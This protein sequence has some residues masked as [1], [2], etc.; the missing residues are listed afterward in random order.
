MANRPSPR[1][2]GHIVVPE[3]RQQKPR[4]PHNRPLMEKRNEEKQRW[5]TVGVTD[6]PLASIPSPPPPLFEVAMAFPLV[7]SSSM[8]STRLTSLPIRHG[9]TIVLPYSRAVDAWTCTEELIS[10]ATARAS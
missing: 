9:H 1:R 2:I 4:E 3:R 10:D 6:L 7:S 8:C 5:Q